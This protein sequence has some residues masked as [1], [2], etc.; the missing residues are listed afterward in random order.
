[1]GVTPT[2]VDELLR[3]DPPPQ[4]AIRRFPKQDVVLGGATIPAG[5]TV[6][7][8]LV[9]AHHDTDRYPHPELLDLDRADNPHLAFGHGPHYCLGAALARMEAEVGL[10]TLLT[11]FPN[12]ALAVPE[13]EL[14]WR[15]SFRNRGLRTLPVTLHPQTPAEPESPTH[16]HSSH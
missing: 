12:L 7:L 3:F 16:N 15:N 1:Q 9:S 5:E 14:Q 13:P 6:L 10:N 11:R 2:T 8:S 4:L